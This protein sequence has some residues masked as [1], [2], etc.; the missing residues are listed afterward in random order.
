[1]VAGATAAAVA[2]D[3]VMIEIRRKWRLITCLAIVLTV[4]ASWTFG[5]TAVQIGVTLVGLA[6]ML[7]I[8][9]KGG[10]GSDGHLPYWRGGSGTGSRSGGGIG[11]SGGGL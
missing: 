5:S 6:A 1:M 3:R 2:G 11:G 10:G 9:G 8:I 4:L 7:F